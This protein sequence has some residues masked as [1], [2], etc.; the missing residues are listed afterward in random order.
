M[1]LQAIRDAI[2]QYRRLFARWEANPDDN[3]FIKEEMG[4]LIEKVLGYI[5]KKEVITLRCGISPH[6]SPRENCDGAIKFHLEAVRP[7]DT[8]DSETIN[9]AVRCALKSNTSLMILTN[10]Q[11]LTLYA[12]ADLDG[13]IIQEKIFEFNLFKDDIT[14]LSENIWSI[15]RKDCGRKIVV[16][17]TR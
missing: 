7:G 2:V 9:H 17:M 16:H 1:E 3:R 5:E 12:I 4:F 6:V 14:I 11:N 8:L 10:G 13:E 15:C